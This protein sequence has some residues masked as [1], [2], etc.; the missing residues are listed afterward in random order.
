MKNNLK[1]ISLLITILFICVSFIGCS[2]ENPPKEQT[3]NN[4]TS[5]S[6]LSAEHG[7]AT[8]KGSQTEKQFSKSD[9]QNSMPKQNKSTATASATN[10]T[11][12]KPSTTK[13][14]ENKTTAKKTVKTTTTSTTSSSITCSIEIECKKVLNNMDNLKAGHEEFVPTDGIIMSTRTVTIDN[15]DTAYDALKEAC[16]KSGVTINAQNSVYGIYVKGFNNIDEFDCGKQSGW[17]YTVN[18]SSPPKSCDKYTVSQGDSII[19]SY[20][21]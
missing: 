18:G 2:N 15:G 19:F 12:Q 16:S 7:N 20:V 13:K 9:S 1:Y 21:C 8:E 10:S 3:L 5:A 11:T 14:A 17:V 6:A 4:I